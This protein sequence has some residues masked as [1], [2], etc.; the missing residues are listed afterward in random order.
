MK[1]VKSIL[2]LSMLLMG[3]ILNAQVVVYPTFEDF[4]SKN[5]KLY[6]DYDG[7]MHVMGKVKLTFVKDGKSKNIACSDMWGFHYKDA[8]FRIDKKHNQP[9]RVI[10]DGKIIYYENGMAHLDM[11]AYNKEKGSF[12]MGYFC[13]L[14]K[15][16]DSDIIPMPGQLVSD[17]R[18]KIKKFKEENPE[19]KE[20]FDC[21]ENDYD[22]SNVRPCVREFDKSI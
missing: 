12:S 22:Y 8:L 9:T 17:A 7:Y 14:S 19:Y 15:S 4:K 18:K 21:I 11:I 3:F 13:Y 10:S 6:D 20:L 2:F 1:N 5:G 16:L